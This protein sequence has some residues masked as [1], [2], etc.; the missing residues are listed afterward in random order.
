[1][2]AAL[3][4]HVQM[5]GQFAF[6]VDGLAAGTFG[7]DA[8]GHF[9]GPFRALQR[10][11]AGPGGGTGVRLGFARRLDLGVPL[12]LLR[13]EQV[14]EHRHYTLPPSLRTP[15]SVARFDPA[16]LRDDLGPAADLDG[17][18][19]RRKLREHHFAFVQLLAV[20]KAGL[21][22]PGQ[23]D[24]R[25]PVLERL[26]DDKVAADGIVVQRNSP[27]TSVRAGRKFSCQLYPAGLRRST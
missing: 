16:V 23:P 1:M 26:N 20:V 4:A 27:P 25:D 7:P 11:G 14:F 8:V 2:M 6:V 12:P 9:P 19:V 24:D 18:R 17:R 13:P 10:R 22:A 21:L 3:G 15:R 5:L